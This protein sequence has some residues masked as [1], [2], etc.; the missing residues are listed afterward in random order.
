MANFAMRR[1][2]RT[3]GD[4]MC[5]DIPA[6]SSAAPARTRSSQAT[7]V[8]P[9]P[10][11]SSSQPALE[12]DNSSE[13]LLF[14]ALPVSRGPS[15]SEVAP[16]PWLQQELP[17]SRNG[18]SPARGRSGLLRLSTRRDYLRTAPGRQGHRAANT[19]QLNEARHIRPNV[20]ELLFGR[21]PTA[22]SEKRPPNRTQDEPASSN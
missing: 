15:L 16:P 7:R 11:Q 19:C 9:P 14:T 6:I 1:S 17:A 10:R 8:G 21:A 20:T 3:S 13:E 12:S 2:T 22:D 5:L 4:R 18:S